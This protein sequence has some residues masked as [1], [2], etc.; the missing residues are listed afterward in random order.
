MRL[1]HPPPNLQPALLARTTLN[2][3]IH[4]PVTYSSSNYIHLLTCNLLFE[5]V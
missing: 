3:P 4:T 2:Y 5:H 1:D